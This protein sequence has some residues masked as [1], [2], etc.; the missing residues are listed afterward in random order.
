M[1]NLV[2]RFN[3]EVR[4]EARRQG[5]NVTDALIANNISDVLD[6]AV[7]GAKQRIFNMRSNKKHNAELKEARELLKQFKAR[8]KKI[9]FS[10]FDEE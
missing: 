3:E 7:R 4:N 8:G 1:D 9:D 10:D 2:Q 6:W 5:V